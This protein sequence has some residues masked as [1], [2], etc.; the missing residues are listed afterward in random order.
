MADD[1]VTGAS[2]APTPDAAA[3]SPAPS[4][5][6]SAPDKPS[7]FQA[8]MGEADSGE[9]PADEANTDGAGHDTA[10]GEELEAADAETGKET[11]EEPPKETAEETLESDDE[12]LP[13]DLKA[14][15][16]K[17]PEL[18]AAHFYKRDLDPLG[19]S[20][21]EAQAYRENIQSLDDLRVTVD[22]A[23]QLDAFEGLFTHPDETAPEE[24]FGVL[25]MVNEESA[26]RFARSLV[27]NAK[28]IAP[29][30]YQE[31]G[32]EFWEKGLQTLEH[33]A[34][35]DAFRRE[36]IVEVRKMIE[37]LGN[38]PARPAPA[39]RA[40]LPNP[41]AEE[42]AK[43]RASERTATQTAQEAL[44]TTANK[45]ADAHVRELVAAVR[46]RRDPDQILTTD[47][48]INSIV[49][50]V[51]RTLAAGGPLQRLF[52]EALND[53]SLPPEQRAAK[54]AA[55]VKARASNVVDLVW[56]K[57]TAGVAERLRK[58]SQAKLGKAAKV[59][60]MRELSGG[61]PAA[62][63][64]KPLPK[65]AHLTSREIFRSVMKG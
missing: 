51:H 48:D 65:G 34:G 49:A 50:E 39:P 62:T 59:V 3:S 8:L 21:E 19:I 60:S 30:L 20:V 41:D 57:K 56:R 47:D 33:A 36:A 26:N 43:R 2:A 31:M 45:Q 1:V 44:R 12:D 32:G 29:D 16:K 55:L 35:D 25:K 64:P 52:H 63:P 24:F 58:A 46:Q 4:E 23:R 38:A 37:E 40:P 7:R 22:R 5:V 9:D 6:S 27:K 61:R 14:V 54:A 42:L 53:T 11:P 13:K 18:R 10:E 28:T 17:F 15:L